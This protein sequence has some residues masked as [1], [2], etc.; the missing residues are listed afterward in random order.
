VSTALTAPLCAGIWGVQAALVICTMILMHEFGHYA[1]AHVGGIARTGPIVLISFD[2]LDGDRLAQ[3]GG[4]PNVRG[5]LVSF[6]SR[7]CSRCVHGGGEQSPGCPA[8]NSGQLHVQI[9]G[10]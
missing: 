3:L 9:D 4:L 6:G 2:M 10:A 8:P 1:V 5:W 7:S